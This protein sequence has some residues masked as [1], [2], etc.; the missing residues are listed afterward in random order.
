MIG[1]SMSGMS[2]LSLASIPPFHDDEGRITTI[3]KI[4]ESHLLAPARTRARWFKIP[5][6]IADMV[7]QQTALTTASTIWGPISEEEFMQTINNVVSASKQ[8]AGDRRIYERNSHP[9][10]LDQYAIPL[11]VEYKLAHELAFIA[12]HDEHA[13]NVSAVSAGLYIGPCLACWFPPE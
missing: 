12:A 13:S 1:S 3:L 6:D 8:K 10:R 9:E 4:V 7:Q 11:R 5:A 2:M